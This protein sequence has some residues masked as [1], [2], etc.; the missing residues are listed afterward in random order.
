MCHDIT[1]VSRLDHGSHTQVTI[2]FFD[3]MDK[4]DNTS[5][6]SDN[7]ENNNSNKEARKELIFLFGDVE[8]GVA[9]ESMLRNVINYHQHV[10]LPSNNGRCC[11]PPTSAFKTVVQPLA[12]ITYEAPMS[13]TTG[14]LDMDL[15]E[16]QSQST[17]SARPNANANAKGKVKPKR[18]PPP[19]MVNKARGVPTPL[20]FISPA[21]RQHPNGVVQV[22]LDVSSPTPDYTH[23]QNN[24]MNGEHNS[25]SV[26]NSGTSSLAPT[27]SYTVDDAI[28]LDTNL[29]GPLS[30]KVFNLLLTSYSYINRKKEEKKEK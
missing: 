19:K 8:T 26:T 21:S 25:V 4:P 16:E 10:Q 15:F 14:D 12:H 2:F 23:S 22:P 1:S 13:P 24:Q 6:K 7:E 5:G 30:T 9:V 3:K 28:N 20:K 27:P 11:L 17:Q 18:K 29:I